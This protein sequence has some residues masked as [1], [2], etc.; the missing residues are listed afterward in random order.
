MRFLDVFVN[1]GVL[2][3]EIALR[4][5]SSES[6]VDECWNYLS[7]LTGYRQ[8]LR[9]LRCLSDDALCV[10]SPLSRE[11]IYQARSAVRALI[12]ITVRETN[13]TEKLLEFFT[14]INV[15]QAAA[16]LNT[17]KYLGSA[18]WEGSASGVRF[19]NGFETG[20]MSVD[21]AVTTASRLCREAYVVI[22]RKADASSAFAPSLERPP[23]HVA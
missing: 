12:E 20:Q 23:E 2:T 5:A 13:R 10:R 14:S 19:A 11:L 22:N 9:A 1:E 4:Q 21:R 18:N 17:C 6:V 7:H 3:A 8:D 16:I 15:H